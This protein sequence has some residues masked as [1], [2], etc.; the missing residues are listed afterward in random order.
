LKTKSPNV[1]QFFIANPPFSKGAF[2]VE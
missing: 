2:L 1:G